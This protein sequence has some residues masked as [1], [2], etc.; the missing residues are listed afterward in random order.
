MLTDQEFDRLCQKNHIGDSARQEIEKIRSSPPSRHVSARSGN[1]CGRYP[2]GKMGQTIQYESHRVELSLI[3]LLERDS[4]ILEHYDQPLSIKFIYEG[5]NG[6]RLGHLHTPD[7]FVIKSDSAGWI[8]CKTE[9]EL[10]KLSKKNPNRYYKD[11]SGSWRCPP[12]ERYAKQLGFFYQVCSDK[13]FNWTLQRNLIFLDD[14]FRNPSPSVEES[15]RK[16]IISIVSE[17]TGITLAELLD[18]AQEYT[19]DDIYNLILTNEV[20]VDLETSLLVEP[21][22]VRIFP[23]RQTAKAYE[24]VNYEASVDSAIDVISPVVRIVSGSQV[25][26][27]GRGLKILH[28]GASEI[29]LVD[30]NDSPVVLKR[31]IFEGLVHQGKITNF[32]TQKVDSIQQEAWA[33]FQMASPEDQTEALCRYEI[34]KPYLEGNPPENETTPKR[35]IRHWKTKYLKAKSKY[36]CGLIGLLSR[37]HAK[38]NR[39][40]RLSQET[41]DLIEKVISENYETIKQKNILSVY[42][43]L[44]VLCEEQGIQEPSYFTFTKKVHNRSTYEQTKARQGRRAAY[45]HKKFYWELS[46]TTPRHGDRPFEICH[47]DHTEADIELVSSE[48]GRNLGR[49]WLTIL[50]DAYSR[51][52]LAIYLTFDPPSYRSCLMVLT[53]L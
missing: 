39:I 40:Q 51:R 47:I 8:E 52:L 17:E 23:N 45:Q 4:N 12:G 33:R 36:N 19:A 2:S 50:T 9:Q 16:S 30:E 14:Y 42:G 53:G 43:S 20:Y 22:R 37:R 3:M 26:W 46:R 25:C 13:D 6:K 31:Q 49:P 35:T 41:Q 48:T 28:A 5:K 38:G 11:E 10:E 18:L 44:L 24:L 1:V 34:I 32:Q 15:A 21:R 27:D 29:T 7:F